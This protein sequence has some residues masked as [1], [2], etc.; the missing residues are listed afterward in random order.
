MPLEPVRVAPKPLLEQCDGRARSRPARDGFR[1]GRAAGLSSPGASASA[2]SNDSTAGRPASIVAQARLCAMKASAG[3]QRG[4]RR[5]G[6]D[7]GRQILGGAVEQALELPQ[8]G[9]VRMRADGRPPARA[10]HSSARLARSA[11]IPAW[12]T[13]PASPARACR[14]R[15]APDRSRGDPRRGGDVEGDRSAARRPRTASSPCHIVAGKRTSRPGFGSIVRTGARSRPSSAGGWPSASQPA[16]GGPA[17]AS[18]GKR[19]VEGRAQPALGMDMGDMMAVRPRAAPSM[20]RQRRGGASRRWRSSGWAGSAGGSCAIWRATAA[21]IASRARR[22]PARPARAARRS[23]CRRAPTGRA[24]G[25]RRRAAREAAP[26][27]ARAARSRRR[28]RRRRP[29]SRRPP[30]IASA[31]R[32]SAATPSPDRGRNDRRARSPAMLRAS[33]AASPWRPARSRWRIR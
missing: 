23:G 11:A 27:A 18:S 9:I 28:D 7:R 1:R 12:R 15:A 20:S 32:R 26:R 17:S 19:D 22:S 31:D 24:A 16:G 5:Q 13:S 3:R 8:P 6:L 30:A 10:E 21:M 2:R 29:A 14:S 4:R 25:P 33:A